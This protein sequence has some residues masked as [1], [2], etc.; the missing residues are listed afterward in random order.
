MCASLFIFCFTSRIFHL[1]GDVTITSERQR[2]LY[3]A[4]PT[5]TLGLGFSGFIQRTAPFDHLLRHTRGCGGPILTRILT[6]LMFYLC[7][8]SMIKHWKIF[9]MQWLMVLETLRE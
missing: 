6:G 4:T 9:L 3:R 5:V 8:S 7:E 1:Y 2:N